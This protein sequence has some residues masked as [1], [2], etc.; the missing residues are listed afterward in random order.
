MKRVFH[1][2]LE[3]R[4]HASMARGAPCALSLSRPSLGI[5][6]CARLQIKIRAL[7]YIGEET[8]SD[9]GQGRRLT[10]WGL[11]PSVNGGS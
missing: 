9:W 7:G 5:I 8:D 4:P 3:L 11:R 1:A 10:D 2:D 6:V